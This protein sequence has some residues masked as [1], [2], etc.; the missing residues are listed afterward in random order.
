MSYAREAWW[1]R[2]G[3]AQ[4][5]TGCRPPHRHDHGHGHGQSGRLFGGPLN[6]TRLGINWKE[7]T[8]VKTRVRSCV[9][10]RYAGSLAQLERQRTPTRIHIMANRT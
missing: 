1:T 9:L 5:T 7:R 10:Y 2:V 6:P 8:Y 4:R 3:I